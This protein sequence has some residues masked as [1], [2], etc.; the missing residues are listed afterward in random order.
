[1]VVPVRHGAG[2][3]CRVSQ[4]SK[5]ADPEGSV[6]MP[7]GAKSP[8]WSIEPSARNTDTTVEMAR[9]VNSQNLDYLQRLDSCDAC[10]RGR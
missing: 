9:V 7:G 3:R 2:L 10:M 8:A 6:S 1:M 5:V 4:N